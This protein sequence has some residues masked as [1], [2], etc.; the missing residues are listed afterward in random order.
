MDKVSILRKLDFGGIIAEHD[1]LLTQCFVKSPELDE[2]TNDKKDLVLGAKGSGKSA[3]WK[4]I[5]DNQQKYPEIYNV[6]FR[7][8]ANPNGDPEFREVLKAISREDFPDDDELREV[9]K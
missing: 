1:N 6:H 5:K 3:L 8:I 4:E 9:L 2:L 7:L